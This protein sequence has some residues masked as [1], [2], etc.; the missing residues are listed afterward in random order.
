MPEALNEIEYDDFMDPLSLAQL[1]DDSAIYAEAIHNLVTKFRR[2]F[3]YSKRKKQVANIK[4]TVYGHFS[5]H[6]RLTP[7]T[8]DNGITLDSIDPEKGYKYIGLIVFPT[9]EIEKIIMR[10]VNKRLGNFAK[11]HAWLAINELTPIEVKLLVLDCCVLGAVLYSSECWGD[12]TCVEEKLNDAE[13]KALR[14]VL[15]IKKGTTIDL[16]YHELQ[17]CTIGSRIRD[18]QYKFFQKLTGMSQDDAIVKVVIDKFSDSLMLSYYRNLKDKNGE[19]E[20][21]EREDRIRS[22]QQ[23]MCKYYVDLDLM[24]KS[25][26]YNSMLS[27]FYR[28]IL[29][30]WRLSNHRL[31]IETGRYT[32]PITL[33]ENRICTLCKVLENEEHVIFNCPRYEDLRRLYQ[34]TDTIADIENFLDPPYTKM[35]DTANFLYALEKRRNDLNL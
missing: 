13:V 11:Y 4:K 3:E 2:I 26:I 15:G 24:K 19:Q 33:R 32:K 30:R 8:V 7:L 22:S 18:R 6:P 9:N 14:A 16:I 10:N 35:K 31:N 21:K 17:R 1:A 5:A 23:S 12:I 29:S 28:I 34:L 25:Q 27:D 20:I